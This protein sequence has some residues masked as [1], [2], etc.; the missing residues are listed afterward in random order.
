MQGKPR[1]E[2][3]VYKLINIHCYEKVK[4]LFPSSAHPHNATST[5]SA[6]N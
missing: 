1:R 4:V 6:L 5:C 3:D 2:G